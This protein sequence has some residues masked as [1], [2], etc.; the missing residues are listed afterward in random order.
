VIIN[1]ISTKYPKLYHMADKRNWENIKKL[2]LLSTTALLDLFDYRG[3]KRIQI[4]SQLRTREFKI[5]HPEHGEVI[6][7]DQDPMTDRPSQGISLN[8]CLEGVTPQEWFEFLNKQTFFWADTKGLKFMLGARLYRKKSHLVFTVNTEKLLRAYKNK[9][10]LTSM[11][12]GSLY[13]MKSR[14]I[15]TFQPLGNYPQMRWITELAIEGGGPNILDY[16]IT[17]EEQ[18]I[19]AEEIEIIQKIWP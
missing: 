16:T 4:E 8:E 19:R 15:S 14:S 5:K 10:T 13:G 17:V 3:D 1:Q 7:R 18:Q 6:I 11:N 2:G 12:T 9:V